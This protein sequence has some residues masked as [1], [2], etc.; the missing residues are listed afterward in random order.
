MV[1]KVKKDP[2]EPKMLKIK[3]DDVMKIL[4]I[5]SSPKVGWILNILL[6]E[7]ID[8]PQKN[9]KEY[10]EKRI[11]ELEKLSD[12]ELEKM[13]KEAKIKKEEFEKE[14]DQKIKEKYNV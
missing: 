4:N 5:S 14:I 3:G 12:Q 6:E 7:V 11:K 9:T 2:I 1:E 8:D 10:L 13:A